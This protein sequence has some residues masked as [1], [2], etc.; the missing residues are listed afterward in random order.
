MVRIISAH[1]STLPML[2]V[3]DCVPP[4]C[5]NSEY[6]R[7]IFR[8]KS[9]MIVSSFFTATVY[10]LERFWALLCTPSLQPPPPMLLYIRGN[11]KYNN[12]NSSIAVTLSVRSSR[13]HNFS[14]YVAT[15]A[16]RKSITI[17]NAGCVVKF[18]VKI[19]S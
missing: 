11:L 4:H 10:Q 8:G 12:P 17:R 9:P 1:H 18:R 16:A 2:D 19:F 6:T 7:D 14:P 15:R 3:C 5:K 13:L